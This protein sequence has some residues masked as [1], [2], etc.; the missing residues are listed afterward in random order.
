MVSLTLQ[1]DH[2]TLCC[3]YEITNFRSRMFPDTVPVQLATGWCGAVFPAD[4][5]RFPE[6]VQT[7]R[8]PCIFQE[9]GMDGD[10]LLEANDHV[11]KCTI[12]L[13]FAC[14]GGRR[15]LTFSN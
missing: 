6:K 8:V 3:A 10:L 1:L 14:R 7:G 11:L 9:W 4:G 12:F 15:W 13:L 2:W 5:A